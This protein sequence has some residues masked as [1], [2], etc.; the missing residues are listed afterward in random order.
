[1]LLVKTKIGPSKIHGIELF[2]AEFIKRGTPTW[3]FTP[4]FDLELN[5]EEHNETPRPEYTADFESLLH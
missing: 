1:M 5:K 2:A 4:G 3:Q